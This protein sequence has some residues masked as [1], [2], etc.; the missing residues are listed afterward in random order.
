MPDDT[1]FDCY[2]IICGIITQCAIC[3]ST[4]PLQRGLGL[5]LLGSDS[6]NDTSYTL[7]PLVAFHHDQNRCGA[8]IPSP[9]PREA[10]LT[11]IFFLLFSF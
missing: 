5:A 11:A 4:Q 6:G 10:I 3:D 8:K 7:G 1:G 9:T 2:H